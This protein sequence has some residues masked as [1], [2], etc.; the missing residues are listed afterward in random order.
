MKNRYQ[1]EDIQWFD[2]ECGISFTSETGFMIFS[3]VQSKSENTKKSC[4]TYEMNS[5]FNVKSIE[6]SVNYIFFGFEHVSQ[7]ENNILWRYNFYSE[8]KTLWKCNK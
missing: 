3:R 6:F 5:I 4:L 7:C 8:D 2:V 1:I